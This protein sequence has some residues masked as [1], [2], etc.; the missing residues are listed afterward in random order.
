MIVTKKY[1][2]MSLSLSLVYEPESIFLKFLHFSA[3][4]YY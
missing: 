3:I 1:Q 4:S 2:F